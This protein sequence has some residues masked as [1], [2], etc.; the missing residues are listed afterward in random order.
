MAGASGFDTGSGGAVFFT[1]CDDGTVYRI[2]VGDAGTPSLGA[3]TMD[4]GASVL[5]TETDGT[6]VWVVVAGESAA[7][8]LSFDA[9]SGDEDT[10]DWPEVL[11]FT[12]VVDTDYAD[13]E[14][15]V[16]HGSSNVS[17]VPTATAV[18][19]WTSKAVSGVSLVDGWTDES[20]SC[21]FVDADGQVA[22]FFI[23]NATVTVEDD[24][25]ETLAA[26]GGSTADGWLAIATASDVQVYDYG[27]DG[28]GSLDQTLDGVSGVT[29][30]E[31]IVGYALAVDDEGYLAVLTELPWVDV[32]ASADEVASGETLGLTFSS[33][34]TGDYT[35]AVGD[36]EV[37][38]GSVDADETVT[39]ELEVGDAFDEGN[40]RIWVYVTADAGTG[41]GAAVVALDDPP[42][43]VD[44]APDD[45]GFGDGQLFVNFTALSAED[46]SSYTIYVST[47]AFTTDDW[48]SSGPA[49]V[50]PD[51]TAELPLTIT[52]EPGETVRQAIKP[53]END[54]L[55]YVG[56]RATD[57]GGQEGP[58]SSVQSEM[59]AVTLSAAEARGDDG[60]WCGVGLAPSGASAAL[61]LLFAARRR[62]ISPPQ[63]RPRC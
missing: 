38:D 37:A 24:L 61:A 30:I 20:S 2:T 40:N 47:E 17:Y 63:P 58:M 15:F 60:R 22:R 33:D 26:I 52:A 44:F 3:E 36:T 7:E 43:R 51:T 25:D 27:E 16:G 21:W 31:G 6:D 55:Y 59:P 23:S 46:V 18:A 39:V 4:A 14:L 29:E 49:Y 5:A 45:L 32:A 54:V 57:D 9:E 41:R 13:G 12:G 50:G 48:P 35:V 62:P 19:A 34:M 28:M 10:T 11:G 53:L 42:D 8:I 56:L 1:G